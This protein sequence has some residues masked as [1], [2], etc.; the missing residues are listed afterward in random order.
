VWAAGFAVGEVEYRVV[1]S[2]AGGGFRIVGE[3]LCI[4]GFGCA[5]LEGGR[6]TLTVERKA[7]EDL[8]GDAARL[9]EF[10]VV[11]FRKLAEAAK[12]LGILEACT[13]SVGDVVKATGR[14]VVDLAVSLFEKGVDVGPI[15]LRSF[16][17]LYVEKGRYPTLLAGAGALISGELDSLVNVLVGG[18]GKFR[19]AVK[20]YLSCIAERSGLSIDLNET[21][22]RIVEDMA[23][24]L[25]KLLASRVTAVFYTAALEAGMFID[26]IRVVRMLDYRAMRQPRP[27]EPGEA[28]L[29]DGSNLVT[30]LFNIGRGRLPDEV[31]AV[32]AAV[33]GAGEVSGFFEATADGRLVLRLV[34]DCLSLAPPSVPEG[35]W[36]AMALMAAALSG[37]TVLAVDEFENSLH[38]SAQ[39][40]LLEELRRSV[41]T[42]I[43]A[44]HSPTVVDAAR[45]LEEIAVVELE[46]GE[47]RIKRVANPRELAEKLRRLG[48]APSEALLYGL[49]ETAEERGSSG[50]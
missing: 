33:L 32:V 30:V 29:E 2:G 20:R 25:V 24:T 6:L 11:P 26:G 35:A 10:V 40:L 38:A 39:E 31:A 44:T 50:P 19:E 22:D 14:E 49:L 12:L 13:A 45:S 21:A 23:R 47:T 41:P 27:L 43:V 17:E 1:L 28:L 37:A 7:L 4:R 5:T 48:L 16:V 36:K 9:L 15:G 3:R 42:V 18:S 8:A 46:A 34:V